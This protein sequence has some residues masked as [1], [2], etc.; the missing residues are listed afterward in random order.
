MAVCSLAWDE[1][2]PPWSRGGAVAVGNYDGVHRGHA[3]L[4]AELRR[5]ARAVN[6]PAVAVTFDP[7]P[8][9]L[10]RPEQFQPV[11]TTAADRAEL[12]QACGADHVL[13]LKTTPALLHLSA[14]E[15][16]DQ[17]LRER[18][19]VRALAE[20]S[21]FGFGRNREGT[22]DTLA[23]LCR[24]A[25]IGLTIVPPVLF[26]GQ[27]VS[28][29]RV[30]KA[31]ERGVVRE[32]ANLLNRPYHLCGSVGRGRQRGRTIG[33]PTA[34]LEDIKTLVPGD[35]VY[36]VRVHRGNETWP[37]AANIGPNPTF[38]EQIRKIE[39][40]LIGFQGDLLGQDLIVDFI[41]RLRETRSFA[42]VTELVEQLHRDVDNA[43]RLVAEHSILLAAIPS[44]TE[45]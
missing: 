7:H 26:A 20:G 2:P 14:A 39:V 32:A 36:A 30:R 37:G 31:L 12:L 10:L 6:G 27:P 25:R 24:Q 44:R 17:V 22:V 8:L 28:S 43:R 29:S 33:F 38:G 18:L 35:G 42:S 4:L 13:F 40:H 23:A 16:F 1:T 5:Q 34:N 21:N 3:A 19:A 41:E 11:L 9:Q 15:F 45:S